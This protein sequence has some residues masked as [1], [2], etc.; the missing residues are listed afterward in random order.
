[1]IIHGMELSCD[2]LLGLRDSIDLLLLSQDVVGNEANLFRKGFQ[3]FR[4]VAA[5]AAPAILII[6]KVG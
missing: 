2:F 4:V 1:M 6:A 5:A 3:H